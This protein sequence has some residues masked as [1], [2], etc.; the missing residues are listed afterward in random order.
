MEG[1]KRIVR[2]LVKRRWWLIVIPIIATLLAIY[3]TRNLKRE[4]SVSTNIFTGVA[5]GVNI[6]S[7][8]GTRID[9]AS[10]NN[11]VDNLLAI[12]RSKATLRELS[13]KLYAQH[14]I[15][16]DTLADNNFITAANY[17]ALLRI[18][19]KEVKKLIDTSSIPNSIVNL[20]EYEKASPKNFVYGLF[21]WFHR[22][23]SYSAL[24]RIETKR[25]SNSD[26]ISIKYTTDDPGIAYNTVLLLSEEFVKQYKLLRFSETNDVIDY[27]REE[28]R[29]LA[30]RLKEAED[31][32]TRYHID[33]KVINYYDQTKIITALSRDY[34]LMLND[35][36]V[37]HSGAVR[38]LDELE[39]KISE[40]VRVLQENREFLSK[41]GEL[42]KLSGEE[43]RLRVSRTDST[44]RA[45]SAGSGHSK[46]IVE[47]ER[48]LKDL[49]TRQITQ[50]YSKDGVAM[51]SYIEKWVDET[52]A[53]EKA[54]SQIEVIREMIDNHDRLY[55]FYSPVGSTIRRKEREIDF[56][57][58]SYLAMLSSLN[59]ALLRQKNLQMSSATLKPIDPPLFPLYS[60]RTGRRDIVMLSFIGTLLFMIGLF[61]VI[62]VLDMTVQDRERAERLIPLK[63]LGAYT[64]TNR[65]LWGKYNMEYKSISINLLANSIIPYL[66]PSMRPN[67][68]NFI[69]TYQEAGKSEVI[70]RL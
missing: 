30:H 66:Q 14:M 24:S 58:Q 23:Y 59:A 28:L 7:N 51:A 33:K 50:K 49:S 3:L 70:A 19:P 55:S 65:L 60:K 18:T 26:M 31:S 11:E 22:H 36:I 42:A 5:S 10:V 16:G 9:W 34:E 43:A 20:K 37:L 21:N 61:L 32:L 47:L 48:E 63:A 39:H 6:E 52:I 1:F 25:V 64:K 67:I 29:K 69:S 41:M 46:R 45:I 38:V 15:E 35:L 13:F 53:K 44:Y 2:L 62:D 54:E 56:I 17:R 12:I 8:I 40:Q 27:F 57:E 68:I 4:Y